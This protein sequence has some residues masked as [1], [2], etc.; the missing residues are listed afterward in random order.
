MTGILDVMSCTSVFYETRYRTM[1]NVQNY[2]W[3][4]HFSK[5]TA[6]MILKSVCL[7]YLTS[8]DFHK[9]LVYQTT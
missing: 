6:P 3:Y 7:H 5:M 9:E 4:Q 1:L 2:V 8:M